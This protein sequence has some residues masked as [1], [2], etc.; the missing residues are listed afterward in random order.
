[1]PEIYTEAEFDLKFKNTIEYIIKTCYEQY[2]AHFSSSKRPNKGNEN[3]DMM[4][5][6]ISKI[7]EEKNLLN[8][9][10]KELLYKY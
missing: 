8:K 10:S 5:D 9:F 2:R 4:I 3:R 6:K 7:I 1:M